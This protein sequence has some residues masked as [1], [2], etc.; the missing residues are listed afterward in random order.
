VLKGLFGWGRMNA[1]GS[2]EKTDIHYVTMRETVNVTINVV[3]ACVCV[4][5]R[6]FI[7]DLLSLGDCFS[8]FRTIVLPRLQWESL[9]FTY[10]VFFYLPV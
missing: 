5:V 9:Y 4:C 8:T 2:G 1:R 3:L 10:S 7:K 6:L